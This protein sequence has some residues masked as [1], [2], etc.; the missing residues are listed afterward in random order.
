MIVLSIDYNLMRELK[1]RSEKIFVSLNQIK[2]IKNSE[3]KSILLRRSVYRKRYKKRQKTN[4]KKY[5]YQRLK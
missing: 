5:N 2:T 4:K 1:I 3:K